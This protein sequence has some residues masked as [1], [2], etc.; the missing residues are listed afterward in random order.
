MGSDGKPGK[1]GRVDP[2]GIVGIVGMLGKGK[3]GRKFG[4]NSGNVG[5]SDEGV[6]KAGGPSSDDGLPK[7]SSCSKWRDTTWCGANER[8]NNCVKETTME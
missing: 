3:T 4:G 6:P 2:M 8:I 5:L 7:E 1:L